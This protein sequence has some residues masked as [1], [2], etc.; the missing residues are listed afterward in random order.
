VVERL[1]RGELDAAA[2]LLARAFADDPVLT[3]LLGAGRERERRLIF[4]TLCRD[5]EREGLIEGVRADGRLAAV[6]VWLPPGA[7]PV[8]LRREARMVPS[9]VRLAGM[10]PRAVPRLLR[11]TPALDRL[12][13]KAP[14][15]FLSL[16]ATEPDLQRGGRG[17]ALVEH[18][19]R[20]AHDGGYVV[21]LDTGRPENV[22]WYRRF[23]FE[24]ADEVRLVPGAP[25]SWGLRTG[26]HP[27]A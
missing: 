27:L 2:A 15:W 3:F 21:H 16:L 5:A 22:P 11:A 17:A 7:H 25:P 26:G 10:H 9:W 6:A 24:V 13:P 12:H 23:G 20:R 8:P 4:G 14:H 18:G 19:L 1:G